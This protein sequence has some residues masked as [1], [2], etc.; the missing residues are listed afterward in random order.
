MIK[1]AKI[2]GLIGFLG[3]TGLVGG[4]ESTYT[5]STICTSYDYDTRIY[6]FTDENGNDWEWE[7]EITDNFEIGY[8][9]YLT[10]DDNHT[11]SNIYDDWI[12]KIKKS[13]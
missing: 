9:Y 3:L 1:I 5:K 7:Q 12:K 13:Y 6:V 10:M 4:W 2:F 11:P 8:S